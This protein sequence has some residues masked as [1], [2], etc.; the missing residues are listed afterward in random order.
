VSSVLVEGTEGMVL[1]GMV[2]TLE[3]FFLLKTREAPRLSVILSSYTRGGDSVH[4]KLCLD[5]TSV[6]IKLFRN[7]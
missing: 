4:A 1:R 7:L 5:W 6:F 2:T 3:L